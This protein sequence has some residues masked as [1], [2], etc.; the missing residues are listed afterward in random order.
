[1]YNNEKDFLAQQARSK[2]LWQRIALYLY[3]P[4]IITLSET[5]RITQISIT[6]AE[7]RLGFDYIL[8]TEEGEFEPD[9][10]N[11]GRL[12]NGKIRF[13]FYNEGKSIE[14]GMDEKFKFMKGLVLEIRNDTIFGTDNNTINRLQVA[15]KYI[16]LSQFGQKSA[17]GKDFQSHTNETRKKLTD[18][19][20]AK[21]ENSSLK[22]ENLPTG[23]SKDEDEDG[24]GDDISEITYFEN[25]SI[26]QDNSEAA[27]TED[28]QDNQDQESKKNPEINQN[29]EEKE[30][31]SIQN[32]EN[33]KK[34]ESVQKVR[35]KMGYTVDPTKEEKK[36]VRPIPNN[37]EQYSELSLGAK[38]EFRS[39]GE[40]IEDEKF[41]LASALE[42]KI[43]NQANIG[44]GISVDES[45]GAISELQFRRTDYETIINNQS[46]GVIDFIF[47]DGETIRLIFDDLA[48]FD[49]MRFE[50]NP[51]YITS[52]SRIDRLP[53]IANWRF[54]SDVIIASRIDDIGAKP[55]VET[56]FYA[57]GS[58]AFK[59][60][61]GDDPFLK[62]PSPFH[63]LVA[64]NFLKGSGDNLEE[65][66]KYIKDVINET[67]E[68]PETCGYIFLGG[69]T[70]YFFVTKEFASQ[71]TFWTAKKYNDEGELIE[72][73]IE[74]DPTMFDNALLVA[75][76]SIDDNRSIANL[77]DSLKKELL[78]IKENPKEHE[79]PEQL[80]ES[81]EEI[82][83]CWNQELQ[84][85]LAKHARVTPENKEV[86]K[87][88]QDEKPSLE[89]SSDQPEKDQNQLKTPSKKIS[90]PS[91]DPLK[92][93]LDKNQKQ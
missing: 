61:R 13:E 9:L 29:T 5:R 36:E 46:A 73:K 12:K 68:T 18:Q 20:P 72:H 27:L 35:K 52:Y 14:A 40:M 62:I 81:L 30:K 43:S 67:S 88:Y 50:P 17:W 57:N 87:E 44:I 63:H 1:M 65:H 54:N 31:T 25:P 45:R 60:Q 37:W 85:I 16:Y 59:T 83:E 22:K 39:I 24:D 78:H 4:D 19:Q 86:P 55:A 93:K 28:D 32:K 90:E 6:A 41:R 84:A 92:K 33:N 10:E 71:M 2:E 7:G 3:S 56:I 70:P 51:L 74:I 38:R 15:A 42:Q 77:L 89:T 48:I 23:E 75:I 53:P 91:S 82:I 66:S 47:L 80:Y 76:H 34:N 8:I 49:V 79:L 69:N 21:E 26:Q 11:R 64:S 58:Y